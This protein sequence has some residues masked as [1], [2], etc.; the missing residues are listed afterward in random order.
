[1]SLLSLTVGTILAVAVILRE[2]KLEREAASNFQQVLAVRRDLQ[3]LSDRLVA[4][5]EDE[6]KNLTRE[7]HDEVGQ[8]MTAMLIDVGRLEARLSGTEAWR[9]PVGRPQVCGGEHRKSSRPCPAPPT[10][11]AG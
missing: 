11:D 9:D 6:R 8:S 1:M 5:Q 2:R 7:L 4:A 10:L 3:R